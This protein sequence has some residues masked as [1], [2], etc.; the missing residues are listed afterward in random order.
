VG[1]RKI[2]GWEREFDEPIMAGKRELV[3]LRDAG[4]YIAALPVT[5]A[6][7]KHWPTAMQC[8]IDAADRGG[9]VMLADVAFRK[10]LAHEET[11]PEPEPRRRRAKAYKVIR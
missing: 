8:L 7:A 4:E 9:I 10:A 3:T 11:A 2:K 1:S 5:E 6:H